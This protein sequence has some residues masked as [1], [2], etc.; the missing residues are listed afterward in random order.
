MIK[1]R[2]IWRDTTIG[3]H[4]T[5]NLIFRL[6]SDL[7]QYLSFSTTKWK[8]KIKMRKKQELIVLIAIYKTLPLNE[9][10]TW[11][12]TSKSIELCP[13]SFIRAPVGRSI[14]CFA[15]TKITIQISK[16]YN[17]PSLSAYQGVYQ[18]YSENGNMQ[19][20]LNACHG[21]MLPHP[22]RFWIPLKE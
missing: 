22:L 13:R 11:E 5:K 17:G 6:S 9:S 16:P 7:V 8:N 10:Q 20:V 1:S 3:F 15:T 12:R 4:F 18:R 14:E 21:E 19:I 2:K